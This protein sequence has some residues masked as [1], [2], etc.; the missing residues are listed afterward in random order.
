MVSI[1]LLHRLNATEYGFCIRGETG[2]PG[3]YGEGTAG[4]ALL[5][6]AGDQ[7]PQYCRL[8]VPAAELLNCTSAGHLAPTVRKVP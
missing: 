2:L 8:T 3:L 1:G 7:S 5:P 4:A 6:G